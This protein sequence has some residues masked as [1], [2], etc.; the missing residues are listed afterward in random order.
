MENML[1]LVKFLALI[2]KN[3]DNEYYGIYYENGKI[4]GYYDEEGRP[5]KSPFLKSPVKYS[6]ISS[7]YNPRRFHPVLKRVRPHYGTD[8]AAARGRL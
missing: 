4:K 1:E 2:F 5:M 7:S 6:R 8:Y 3:Y